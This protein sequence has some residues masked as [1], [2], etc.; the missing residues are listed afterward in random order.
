MKFRDMK[1]DDIIVLENL[2]KKGLENKLKELANKYYIVDLQF[3]TYHTTAI[4]AFTFHSALALV[5][6]K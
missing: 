6:Y 5:R 1:I 2:S 3:A 4:N